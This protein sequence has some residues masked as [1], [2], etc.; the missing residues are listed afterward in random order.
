LWLSREN[1][2][3]D[4]QPLMLL[5]VATHNIAIQHRISSGDYVFSYLTVSILLLFLQL[6]G[7]A[8]TPRIV[9]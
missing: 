5:V 9:W 8:W 7:G 4:A 2:L 3:I 6:L 1:G